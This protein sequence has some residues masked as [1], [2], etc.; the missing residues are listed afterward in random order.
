MGKGDSATPDQGGQDLLN[1]HRWS[2]SGS[3]LTDRLL[4]VNPPGSG[5]RVIG[6]AMPTFPPAGRGRGFRSAKFTT[7]VEEKG[8]GGKKLESVF[9]CKRLKWNDENAIGGIDFVGVGVLIS[10]NL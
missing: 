5:G 1:A 6:C 10:T 4:Y 2:A 8:R 9:K 7:L 3:R